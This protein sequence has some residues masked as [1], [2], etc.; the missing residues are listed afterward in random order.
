MKTE[1]DLEDFFA[2]C[3]ESSL[4]SLV[5]IV[6]V[7]KGPLGKLFKFN[8]IDYDD[9][10]N[11]LMIRVGNFS[12]QDDNGVFAEIKKRAKCCD[13]IFPNNEKHVCLLGSILSISESVACRVLESI[14]VDCQKLLS[15]V[16]RDFNFEVEIFTYHN[17]K[18]DEMK[19]VVA[20]ETKKVAIISDYG[21]DLTERY[22]NEEPKPFIGR[23]K[24]ITRLARMLGRMKKNSV[25]LL[26]GSGVGKT[27][28]IEEFAYRISSGSVSGALS[29]MT[30]FLLKLDGVGDLPKRF[31][32]MYGFLTRIMELFD[33]LNKVIFVMDWEEITLPGASSDL[34]T[35]FDVVNVLSQTFRESKVRFILI[36]HPDFYEDFVVSCPQVTGLIGVLRLEEATEAET[37]QV[38]MIKKPSYESHHGIKFTN[39]A[40]VAILKHVMKG[41][42]EGTCLPGRALELLDD[43]G[44][45]FSAS[46]RRKIG[47]K[48]VEAFL[49]DDDAEPIIAVRERGYEKKLPELEK[50]LKSLVIGQDYACEVTADAIMALNDPERP[51]ASLFFTGPSGVGKT[52]LAQILAKTLFDDLE[53]FLRIDMSEYYDKHEVARLI[54]SPPGYV[55]YG[56]DS[57]MTKQMKNKPKSVILLDEIEKAHHSIYDILLQI[58]DYGY[59]TNGKGER[60]SFR[61]A[62]IIMTSNI[63]LRKSRPV[64]FTKENNSDVGQSGLGKALQDNS[65]RKEFIGR[66]DQL[67]EFSSLSHD[68]FLKIIDLEIAKISETAKRRGLASLTFMPEAKEFIVGCSD[69][70]EYGARNLNH[71]LRRLVRVPLGKMLV[72]GGPKEMVTVSVDNSGLVFV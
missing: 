41:E 55:G 51:V 33:D 8:G 54:G 52:L 21:V 14:N 39:E 7:A 68:H 46:K 60:L 43:V 48:E 62:I 30:V 23:E 24:Q 5:E 22:K 42:F 13:L 61:E 15:D 58:L 19:K 67:V 28:L 37:K 53:C 36:G 31:S 71:V 10:L 27:A 44:S 25:L 20:V 11:R 69:T 40:V 6:K 1:R 47:T 16:A 34:F 63:D 17:P 66:I 29:G 12:Y 70:R 2:S 45:D 4:V 35:T 32:D 57:K 9:L 3:E 50:K 59:L 18:G 38:L 49:K 72:H 56:E 26:G 65:F 64:G